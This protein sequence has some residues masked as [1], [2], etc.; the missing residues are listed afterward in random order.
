M[1]LADFGWFTNNNLF[2]FSNLDHSSYSEVDASCLIYCNAHHMVL[3]LTQKMKLKLSIAATLLSKAARLLS[4]IYLKILKR[5]GMVVICL[6]ILLM[7]LKLQLFGEI[8]IWKCILL[9]V[10]LSQDINVSQKTALIS[11]HLE[12]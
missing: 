3:K 11:Q 9:Y 7:H 6:K 5:S 10:H 8:I 1:L 12:L 4:R 2:H